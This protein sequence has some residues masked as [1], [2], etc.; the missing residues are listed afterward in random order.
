MTTRLATHPAN[1]PLPDTAYA[2]AWLLLRSRWLGESPAVLHEV[3][4]DQGRAVAVVALDG[5]LPQTTAGEWLATVAR[6]RSE[7]GAPPDD[8]ATAE[9]EV[10]WLRSAAA[11]RDARAA[12]RLWVVQTAPRGLRLH[13]DADPRCLDADALRILLAAIAATA[14]H[15]LAQPDAPLSAIPTAPPA[16]L[17]AQL[18]TWNRPVAPVDASLTVTGCF[19]VQ[20][21]TDPHAIALVEG[22]DRMCYGELDRRSHV[23]ARHLECSGVRAGERVGLMLDRS[24]DA[25]VAQLA[26]LRAGA[27]YVPIPTDH[28]P[29]QISAMLAQAGVRLAVT[30]RAHD[31]L[32]PEPLARIHLDAWSPAQQDSTGG[33]PAI[34]G[35]SIAYVM[36]TSGSTGAPKAIEISHRAILRLVVDAEYAAFGPG[37]SMLHAAPLG[38]DAATLEIWGPLLNGGCCVIHDERIPTGP[39]LARTVARHGVHTAWLTA[40]LFN[41]VVDDDPA[42]LRG[43]R[44]LI[45]GGEALSVAHVRRALAALPELALTNGYGPT[46]CTTFAATYRVPAALPEDLRSVP[47]GRP[48][49]QTVLRVLSPALDLLPTGLVG[50]LCIGGQGLANGY[51]G[52]PGLTAERFVADPFG[53]PG[54]RLYRTGDLARWLPDGTIEFVGRRDGQIKIH[55][56]RIEPGEVEAAL[57]SHPDIRSCAVVARPDAAGRTRLVAYLV[58]RAEPLAWDTLRAHLAARL[59]AALLPSAQVWLPA[60][61]HT[62]NGKLDRGALP[63]PTQ[64]RPALSQPYAQAASPA[65]RQVCQA[66]AAVLQIDPVGRDDNF[67]DLGGDSLRAVQVLA[68]LQNEGAPRLSTNLFFRHPTPAGIAARLQAPGTG[69]RPRTAAAP[70]A[71][72]AGTDAVALIGTAGRFPGAVDVEQ[73]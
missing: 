41:A 45:I 60:L 27:V 69:A 72:A 70:P 9:P 53:Q 64:A 66:F 63:A 20:A 23:L 30:V 40:A 47:L 7:A 18:V 59:P 35:E 13:A 52:Q 14:D 43:L 21:R 12:V 22:D 33:D 16:D 49:Q 3:T 29:Q 34:D 37:A 67:F 46:E 62:P 24:M 44:H 5:S 1:G 2:A 25:V 6:C 19:Q 28:P 31:A 42:H 17:H 15:V 68:L 50:E 73:F 26:I 36:C 58:A 54:D 57:L 11:A 10:L 32:V 56:H 4:A 8:G 55:G 51:L 48:I 39:G 38:F 61:P 71:G 65:E